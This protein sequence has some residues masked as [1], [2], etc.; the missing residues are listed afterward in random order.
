MA[1]TKGLVLRTQDNGWAKV[2]TEKRA[3]AV[4]A[5]RCRIVGLTSQD[6]RWWPMS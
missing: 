3:G 5:A 1:H 2:A 4:A 6:L